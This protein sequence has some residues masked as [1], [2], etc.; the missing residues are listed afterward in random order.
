[1]HKN[2]F[3]DIW[4]KKAAKSIP[5]SPFM[6]I[7]AWMHQ[8]PISGIYAQKWQKVLGNTDYENFTKDSP[9]YYF[10]VYKEKC[11]KNASI[12]H[13][14]EITLQMHQNPFSSIYTI[15]L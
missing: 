10:Q 5:K 11:H 15:K 2:L 14:M 12:P 9:K 1:M 7:V 6:K 8:N 4:G 13:V 3:S